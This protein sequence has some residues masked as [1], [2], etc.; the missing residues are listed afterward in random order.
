M[1]RKVA[2]TR[3]D[4]RTTPQRKHFFELAAFIGG[5]ESLSNFMSEASEILA[6]KV[7]DEVEDSRVLSEVDRDL[8]LSFLN[9][10]PEPNPVLK[11]AHEKVAKLCHVNESGE[12]IYQ[13]EDLLLKQPKDDLGKSNGNPV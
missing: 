7:L 3:I 13:V 10:P 6:K 5:Y 2:S 8:L 11:A 4:L 1:R 12:T 9:N